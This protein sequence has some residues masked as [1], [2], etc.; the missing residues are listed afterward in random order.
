MTLSKQ[1]ISSPLEAGPSILDEYNLP[2]H[3]TGALEYASKKLARKSLH[4]TL[5][6]VR[7]EYQLPSTPP[8]CAR[9]TPPLPTPEHTPGFVSPT[10]F[11]SPV[12]GLRQLVRRGTS[13]SATSTT[14]STTTSPDTTSNPSMS[15]PASLPSRTEILASPRRWV[16][17]STPGSPLP[18]TPM[19]PH[20]PASTAT[21]SSS[22]SSA[23]T[24]QGPN[25][26]GIRLIY[27]SPLAPKAE[28]TLRATILRT[29]RKFRIGTGWLPPATPASAC[30]LNA[31]L[32]RR[33]IL[34]N[35]V[36]F[37]SEGLT[38]LGLDRLY[39]FKAALAAY[40]RTITTP[41]TTT[42]TPTPTAPYYPVDSSR[43]IEDAV[44]SL[45]RL[46]LANAGRPVSRPDLLRSYDW[47]GVNPRALADVER[48]YRR[49]YGGPG[50]AGAF[51]PA[52][53]PREQP[54]V[55]KIGTPPPPPRAQTTPVLRLDTKL[56][57]AVATAT[58]TTAGP[59][60]V[61]PKPA[62]PV[63]R[64]SEDE[65]E[66]ARAS[67]GGEVA[68]ML[69]PIKLDDG[70]LTA[71]E[72]EDGDGDLTARPA[73]RGGES[74]DE[75]LLSPWR[76]S[77]QSQSQRLGPMTPN[78]YE[79]ISPVTRSEWGFLFKNDGWNHGRTAA[80]ETCS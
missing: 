67:G 12:A 71:V 2:S 20:T 35:E 1:R 40:A 80:V 65:D 51:E 14:P 21:M 52:T 26:F 54:A 30:G 10:R 27:T 56:A 79:D 22:T 6:V 34:Q 50:R 19:T 63:V 11:T 24:Q 42:S 59:R 39:T 7:K 78:G 64:R 28:K 53:Q 45:R 15:S 16:L 13:K 48:M 41:N 47:L 38:L 69:L 76:S 61:R 49:A 31:D 44:D 68:E 8:P 18:C 32:V 73:F 57:A 23:A 75:M 33:S 4:I 17:P 60:L 43:S 70:G 74:I 77:A 72:D 25:E 36:L 55:V 9:P 62:K 29:E 37:S 5:V 58:A 3:L 66:N 46:V